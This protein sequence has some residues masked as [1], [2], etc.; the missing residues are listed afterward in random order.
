MGFDFIEEKDNQVICKKK[1][2]I[3]IDQE[4]FEDGIAEIMDDKIST[5]GILKIQVGSKKYNLQLPIT[6][7]VNAK[8]I[9]KE[10]KWY[11]ID[12]EPNDIIIDRTVFFLSA[13]IGAKNANDFL[14]IL[15]TAKLHPKKPEELV[16]I[17]EKNTKLNGINVDVQRVLIEAMVSELCRYKANNTIP[18]RI[19][20]KTN[21][22]T[23][24]DFE[25]V[26]IKEISRLSSVFNAISFEDVKKSLEASVLMTREKTDQNISPV[27]KVL[28]Y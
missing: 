6:I 22:A 15:T 18:Y 26:N 1:L 27:E 5:M 20:T 16:S 23:S 13:T 28:K 3:L 21:K 8:E 14:N 7:L 24:E 17:F 12:Y 10:D 25:V 4:M 19:A 2:T 9:Y 11:K